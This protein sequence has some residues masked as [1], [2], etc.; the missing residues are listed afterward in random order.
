[1]PWSTGDYVAGRSPLDVRF[2]RVGQY[3][4]KEIVPPFDDHA[5]RVPSHSRAKLG[6]ERVQGKEPSKKAAH[7]TEVYS[8]TRPRFSKAWL[9]CPTVFKRSAPDERVRRGPEAP[10]P[11][12]FCTETQATGIFL[13]KLH[14]CEARLRFPAIPWW[15]LQTATTNHDWTLKPCLENLQRTLPADEPKKQTGP[16]IS[17]VASG[18]VLEFGFLRL[19]P[20]RAG[21]MN[22]APTAPISF[23]NQPKTMKRFVPAFLIVLAVPASAFDNLASDN[24][25]TP[26]SEA[27]RTV[28]VD[29]TAVVLDE[30]S[31][32]QASSPLSISSDMGSSDFS[33]R[34]RSTIQWWQ[35]R[36]RYRGAVAAA[37][38]SEELETA[39]RA[40]WVLARWQRGILAD[41]PAE[42]AKKLESFS[43]VEAIE[44][45]LETG[46]FLAATIAMQEAAG[47]LDEDALI[48]RVSMT[49][50]RRFPVYARAA[51]MTEQAAELFAFLDAACHSKELAV[52]RR[53]WARL[54]PDAVTDAPGGTLD[55][56]A[57][58]DQWEPGLVAQTQSLLHWID[59]DIEAA[60][61]VAMQSEREFPAGQPLLRAIRLATSQWSEIAAEAIASARQSEAAAERIAESQSNENSDPLMRKSNE[62][63]IIRNQEE[64]IG[65]WSDVLIAADR[66]GDSD[67]RI[68]AV[69]GLLRYRENE[70]IAAEAQTLLWRSLMIHGEM[71]PALDII[72]R[73]APADA[74]AIAVDA[75][76]GAEALERLGFPV[77]QIDTQLETWIDDAIAA[78]RAAT[79]LTPPAPADG[80]RRNPNGIT[81]EIEAMFALMGLL[82]SLSLDESAWRIAD[83]LSLPDLIAKRNSQTADY[84][85]RD[86][87]LLSL[88]YTSHSDWMIRLAMREWEEAPTAISQS[89]VSKMTVTEDYQALEVLSRFVQMQSPGMAES[90][91][92]RIACEIARANEHDRRQH[93][94]RISELSRVLEDG[95]L[96]SH[97][98]SEAAV[99]VVFRSSSSVWSELFQAHG[100]PDLAEVF[101]RERAAAGDLGAAFT[102]AKEYRLASSSA[103]AASTY[104]AIWNAVAASH[105]HSASPFPKE[106]MTGVRAVAE[107]FR[108]ARDSGDLK[109]A[110]T[111]LGQLR[112]MACT[113]SSEMRQQ[114][115]DVLADCGQWELADAIYQSLLKI[116]SITPDDPQPMID[117]ARKYQGFAVKA[118][119]ARI[120]RTE[121]TMESQAIERLSESELSLRLRAIDG[122]DV[123]FAA[124]L[125]EIDFRPELYLIYPR[126]IARERLELAIVELANANFNTP[127][128]GLNQRAVDL[129]D[130]LQQLDQMDITTAEGILPKLKKVGLTDEVDSAMAK[131]M[132]AATSHLQSFP[133]DAVTANN[134]AWGAAV[135]NVHLD[136]ALRLSRHAVRFE[137]DSAIYRD[138]L[139][140]ILA[141][142][143]N[144]AEAI[145]IE[146]ACLIDDPGQ[147]HLHEQIERFEKKTLKS[148]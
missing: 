14:L 143:G 46:R 51:V 91:K 35:D 10:L 136:D 123:A 31:R 133:A 61:E 146:R 96:R 81:P 16:R 111:I 122:F 75:S 103:N 101:L 5:A 18:P 148:H 97:I 120:E 65:H 125:A 4:V 69:E 20:T 124:T 1:M 82:D 88:R 114:I 112:A 76:R 83:R 28:T 37:A 139:A 68:A 34:R 50:D 17:Q 56:P 19:R 45:L 109:T 141:R 93:A 110:D 3:P 32:R 147:W 99:G 70:N 22:A 102:L 113:P 107:Q 100:R 105:T 106:I 131:M 126:L 130:R 44:F 138:T 77:D 73:S 89:L 24:G 85:V 33:L 27:D 116:I 135:N 62:L 15:R 145:A 39:E 121:S 98:D 52:S 118:T 12:R 108:L 29:P 48:A 57:V 119:S 59:N 66:S 79:S 80:T 87:V 144:N 71:D 58:A 127:N 86:Y 72:G 117:V 132:Q 36:E 6:S 13:V 90:E 94:D 2:E 7:P 42:V 104:D 30:A 92:F 129:L 21:V 38:L 95:S 49:L 67:R 134:V 84:L 142:L 55:L 53:D 26:R 115:A 140:E 60:M 78:Q 41:T 9:L 64:A 8:D 23:S 63:Q 11:H 43:P 25:K 137:P 74:A 128:F 47:T 40:R 54:F